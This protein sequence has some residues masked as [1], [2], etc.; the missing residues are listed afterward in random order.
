MATTAALFAQRLNNGPFDLSEIAGEHLVARVFR[1]PATNAG[2]IDLSQRLSVSVDLDNPAEPLYK[3]FCFFM[4]NDGVAMIAKNGQAKLVKSM[5]RLGLTANWMKDHIVTKGNRFA[6]VVLDGRTV[7]AAPA[8]WENLFRLVCETHPELAAFV[9]QYGQECIADKNSFVTRPEF[10]ARYGSAKAVEEAHMMR[11]RKLA[12]TP[13]RFLNETERSF[14]DFRVMM[15]QWF[16]ANNFFAGTG[17]T[18]D[19]VTG[20][21]G[22]SESFVRN[23]SLRELV[24][25][26]GACIVELDIDASLL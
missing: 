3:P 11:D 23:L 21:E 2:N 18:V 13:R 1:Y 8:T 14:V 20:A 9:A 4:G 10:T 6:I 22:V 17:R 26:H 25:R 16:S 24:E 12:V 15:W 5:L 7:G 19:A